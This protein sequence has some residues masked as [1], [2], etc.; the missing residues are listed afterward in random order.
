MK[1]TVILSLFVV[2]YLSLKA[3]QFYY[4]QSSDG[5]YLTI[6][7]NNQSNGTPIMIADFV[8]DD[9]QKWTIT[10]SSLP[11]QDH[12][13]YIK[14][15]NGLTLDISFNGSDNGTPIKLWPF[16]GNSAQVWKFE[17]PSGSLN[18]E[19]QCSIQAGFDT[20]TLDF[21][22]SNKQIYI[23][24]YNGTPCQKWKITPCP[25]ETPP[26]S[27]T[28][29]VSAATPVVSAATPMVSMA[30]RAFK[31]AK[32][33]TP[34]SPGPAPSVTKTGPW[35]E[36]QNVRNFKYRTHWSLRTNDPRY[37]NHIDIIVEVLNAGENIMSGEVW[38]LPC[39]ANK[40]IDQLLKFMNLKVG[41]G[42]SNTIYATNCGTLE[43][44]R[45][46]IGFKKYASF[47]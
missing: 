42:R 47:D 21:C 4:I 13:F 18:S 20:R 10:G 38:T 12:I 22:S 27:A 9:S 35:T 8:G 11:N 45:Y 43:N 23:W 3:Q 29:V 26:V 5:R 39:N 37:Q 16:D 36:W 30:P 40:G 32:I 17:S 14:S 44:P 46:A 28:P 6:L 19:F 2:S 25:V 1:K 31:R 7:D 24:A 34:M 15:R 41:E 33:A